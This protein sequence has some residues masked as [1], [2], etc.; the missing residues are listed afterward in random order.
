MRE[1]CLLIDRDGRIL[2]ADASTS[3]ARLPDSRARWEAIWEHRNVLAAVA[4][5]H[6]V[7]PAAFSAED[8]STMTAIDAALGTSLLYFVV[9]PHLTIG[10]GGSVFPEPWWADLLRL[11]SGMKGTQS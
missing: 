3:A 8:R 7:G 6:P 1:V 4:H 11:S 9:A 2:W 10:R 5:S